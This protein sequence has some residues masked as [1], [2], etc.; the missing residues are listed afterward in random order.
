MAELESIRNSVA[1]GRN[2]YRGTVK[3]GMTPT[4]G[5]IVTLP[6]VKR[7]REAHP[8]LS[9]RVASAFSG[10]LLDWL[11]RGELEIVVSYDP[12]PL[13]SLTIVPVLTER[14]LVVGPPEAGFSLDRPVPFRHLAGME[15]ILPSPRH[16]LRGIVEACARD[17]GTALSTRV[18]VESFTAMIALV[19]AGLGMT[20]LPLAPIHA[21]VE[22]GELGAAPLADPTPERRLVLAY[23]AERP[24][25]PAA[26]FVGEE[27]VAIAGDL[28]SRGIWM[29]EL[30]EA[31]KS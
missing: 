24:L 11:Q 23:S 21:M 3:V 25:N 12:Q 30:P 4:V 6:L 10:F 29:G 22:G 5:Q 7:L 14:L 19:R 17:T 9:V 28:V 27:F 2:S 8:M 31:A 1:E 13:R 26:R 16:G 15:M 18:E 20:V